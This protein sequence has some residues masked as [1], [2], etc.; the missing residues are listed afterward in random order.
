[1]RTTGRYKIG[2]LVLESFALDGGAMF[3]SIPKAIWNKLIPSDEKNRI[4]MVT[5]VLFIEG[6]NNKILVDCGNGDKWS[7]K[8]RDI[9]EILP[10]I[11]KPVREL[12]GEID[13]LILTHLHFDHAA[14]SVYQDATGVLRL[15]FPNATHILQSSNWERANAP[16]VR[17]RASYL[18]DT[19]KELS[20]AK[21]ELVEDGHQP[22]PGI[23]LHR[24]D[25]HTRGLQWILIEDELETVA[26]PSDLIPTAHHINLPFVMGY[27]LCAET[28]MHEKEQF[29]LKASQN[30]WLVIFEHDYQTI[31][32]RVR[33][34]QDSKFI[35]VPEELGDLG[36]N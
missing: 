15:S 24:V 3:G 27:D 4:P 16:G 22:F 31:G 23:S 35:F 33:K 8:Q 17:E 32:G 2:T 25:G 12:F 28:T 14:G 26:Y 10:Q 11:K 29:L 34:E 36:L 20:A 7:D 19:V 1:M 5:R 18:T 9:F 6:P 30:N 13:T 21:L